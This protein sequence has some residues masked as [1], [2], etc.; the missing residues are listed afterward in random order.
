MAL[1]LA[2][3]SLRRLATPLQRQLQQSPLL[4]RKRGDP[5][6]ENAALPL[7]IHPCFLLNDGSA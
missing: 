3:W 5:V 1:G 6:R 4:G 7:F 2:G